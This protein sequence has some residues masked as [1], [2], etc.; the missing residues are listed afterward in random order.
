MK[1]RLL[2]LAVIGLAIFLIACTPTQKVMEKEVVIETP[3]DSPLEEKLAKEV[4]ATEEIMK[5]ETTVPIPSNIIKITSS[6]FEPKMLTVK[7]GTTV[8]FVNEDS[9]KHW[10]ASAMHPTHTV[11][12]GSDIKK[13]G[14]DAEIFDACHGLKQGESFSFTFKEKGSWN[15][16]DHLRSSSTGKI[17][18][19]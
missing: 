2:L 10:P 15:Y 5:E 17:T 3:E 16:H 13:C 14:T 1:R 7:T 18:V 8:T 6:G 19:E 12:P 11:Y 9:N 4:D